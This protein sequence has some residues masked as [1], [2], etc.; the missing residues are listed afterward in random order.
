MRPE[1]V[2]IVPRWVVPSMLLPKPDSPGE[3][4]LVT[5]FSSLRQFI[6]KQ[7][8]STPTIEETKKVLAKYKHCI[9]LDLSNFYWQLGMPIDS[10]QYLATPHPYGGLV[11]YMVEPQGLMN[12]SE[13]GSE[14]LSRVFQDLIANEK[15]ARQA[16]GIFV[17]ANTIQDLYQNYKEVL[18]LARANGLTFKPKKIVMDPKTITVWGWKKEGDFLVSA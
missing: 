7:E 6:L 8:V 14:I 17:L 1:D 5:D 18:K 2:G 11:V 13:H 4:R 12:A 15:I 3:F 10:S 9:H 16:D